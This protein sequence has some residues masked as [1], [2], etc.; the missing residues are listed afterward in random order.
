VEWVELANGTRLS[1]AAQAFTAV[2]VPADVRRDGDSAA[3]S[4]VGGAGNDS[5]YGYDGND[6]LEGGAG[7][8]SLHGG[9]GADTYRLG[10]GHDTIFDQGL[11]TDAVDRIVLTVNVAAAGLSYARTGDGELLIRW[12]GGSVRIAEAFDS[13]Y[14]VEQLVL[15]G[16]TIIDLATVAFETLG[17]SGSEQLD[18]NR[19]ARGSRADIIRGFDGDDEIFGYDGA[20]T[21][22]GGLGNDLLDGDAGGDR[23]IVLGHDVIRDS[24]AAGDAPDTIELPSHLRLADLTFTRSRDGTL[25]IAWSDG[26]VTLEEPTSASRVV[27]QLRFGDGSVVQIL[28]QAFVTT[29]SHGADS[30]YGNDGL[31]SLDDTILGLDGND[32]MSGEEGQ[33]WLQGG[34]GADRGSGGT[35]HD[36]VWGGAG[37][38]LLEGGP[39]DDTIVGNEGNDIVTYA[40]A[41]GRVEIDLGWMENQDTRGAGWDTLLSIEHV[42]GSTYGDS[43][44][45]NDLA[46]WLTGGRG[47]DVLAGGGGA[48]RFVYLA[49]SDSTSAAPDLIADFAPGDRIDLSAIDSNR[50]VAGDQAFHLG[51][52]PDRAGDLV[53]AFDAANN[54]TVISLFV[55][56]D[57]I[58]D[59]TI[60]IAGRPA[61]TAADFIF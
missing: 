35:G 50:G 21:L 1:L 7:N 37:D 45:G 47:G 32:L 61:L 53:L 17:T 9:R 15:A 49:L 25:T 8:D 27:E 4:L 20:D 48:D 56:G 6:T 22:D 10:L 39:G 60:W 55:D 36:S 46:N 44:R 3:N 12:S 43:L 34:E 58:A 31:G 59:V 54:R 2:V 19:E 51:A 29:G 13:A 52:T 5:L 23:Y 40:A 24:G 33:D 28:D 14:G 41:G 42:I 57:A 11:S 26:S 30:L 16:G 18:G 38:D